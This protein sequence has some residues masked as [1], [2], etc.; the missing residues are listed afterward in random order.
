[1]IKNTIRKLL[2]TAGYDLVKI[3]PNTPP[4]AS[5]PFPVELDREETELLASLKANRLTMTSFERLWATLMAC[6]HV[7]DN[8][9]PGDFV[10]CGVWRGGNA[11]LAAATFKRHGSDRKVYLFDTFEGMTEP[12][13]ADREYRG[14]YARTLLEATE[15][16][17]DSIW[18]I[19]SL[20][21]V[22]E[23]FRKAGLLDDNV[24]FVKGDVCETLELSSNIPKQISV[25]RLDTDWY[26]STRKELEIL[27]P[28]LSIG[29]SLMIDDYGH[30]AGS[31]QA[32]DE[33]FADKHH[34]PFLQ[35]IDYT[36]RSGIKYA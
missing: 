5:S 15:R 4:G 28:R 10:E 18:C 19:A 13:E 25:L 23:N 29:G 3:P 30:W 9:I 26:E 12:T 11:L 36:G 34:H 35:C 7:I 27:Y 21:D 6:K 1:M 33:Y 32:T 2:N 24:V 16:K 14:D 17:G 20:E 31:R 22:R 8:N